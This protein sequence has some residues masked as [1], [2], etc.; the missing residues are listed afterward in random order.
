M[1]AEHDSSDGQSDS[2]GVRSDHHDGEDNLF[3][4]YPVGVSLSIHAKS[5]SWMAYFKEV[6]Q[7]ALTIRGGILYPHHA[8]GPNLMQVSL[9]PGG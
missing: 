8:S 4:T 7:K 2:K 1:W 3:E 6:L 5:L 9:P